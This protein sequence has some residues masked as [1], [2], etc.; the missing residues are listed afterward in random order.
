M[1][2]VGVG[3][4]RVFIKISEDKLLEHFFARQG[5]ANIAL[6]R[7]RLRLPP[8]VLPWL[9]EVMARHLWSEQLLQRIGLSS[10]MG[11]PRIDGEE[12]SQ[13]V[14]RHFMIGEP[15]RMAVD[16]N[17]PGVVK[18]LLEYGASKEYLPEGLWEIRSRLWRLELD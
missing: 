8:K 16:L 14:G 17:R 18:L 4:R 15:M 9:S 10:V 12:P 13:T 5:H 11:M 7:R 2:F 3:R 6:P 1:A